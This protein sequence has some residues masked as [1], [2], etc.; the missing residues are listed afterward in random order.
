MT[1]RVARANGAALETTRCPIR[2]DGGLLTSPRGA[3]AVGEDTAAIRAEL[4]IASGE[5]LP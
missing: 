1:Q 3:P 5:N 4:G 2:I